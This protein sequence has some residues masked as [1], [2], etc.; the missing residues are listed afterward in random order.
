[1]AAV[2]RCRVLE[3]ALRVCFLVLGL[4]LRCL[5]L[6]QPLFGFGDGGLGGGDVG[7]GRAVLEGLKLGLSSGQS[8]LSCGDRLAR[9]CDLRVGGRVDGILK[10][11]L[12]QGESGLGGG[13]RL[14]GFADVGI[15]GAFL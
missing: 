13:H 10:V 9:G 7:V 2:H 15:S 12:R 4:V 11:V 3:G 8:S 1:M 6:R 5:G 14:V